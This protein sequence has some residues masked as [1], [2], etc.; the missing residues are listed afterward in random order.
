MNDVLRQTNL[1][2]FKK[3]IE[4]LFDFAR[5]NNKMV[6]IHSN[7]DFFVNGISANSPNLFAN[8][9]KVYDE[10][11]KLTSIKYENVVYVDC[12]HIA[13]REYLEAKNSQNI[14]ELIG[15]IQECEFTIEID[16]NGLIDLIDDQSDYGY[17][18]FSGFKDI[19]EV[20]KCLEERDYFYDYFN[21]K[22]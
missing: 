16:S 22:V 6:I 4:D 10:I 13:T 1:S 18:R 21:V 14:D 17:I 2:L 8:R 19:Y 7:C 11:I 12:K 20:C 15:Y 9:P 5:L 3:T